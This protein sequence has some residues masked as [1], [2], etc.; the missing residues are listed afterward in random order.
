MGREKDLSTVVEITH[1]DV[2]REL[3]DFQQQKRQRYERSYDME[4]DQPTVPE[5]IE[6]VATRVLQKLFGEKRSVATREKQ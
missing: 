6:R 1:K 4:M 5:P 2:P 3:D